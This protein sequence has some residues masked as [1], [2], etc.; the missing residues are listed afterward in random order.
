MRG[1]RPRGMLWTRSHSFLDWAGARV[2]CLPH[3]PS[4]NLLSLIVSGRKPENQVTEDISF[5][6]LQ[7]WHLS[8]FHKAV[9]P[10]NQ[11]LPS[12]QFPFGSMSP[13]INLHYAPILLTGT[14]RQNHKPR[15]ESSTWEVSI[16]QY[17]PVTGG[18]LKGAIYH[19]ENLSPAEAQLAG[20]L[21]EACRTSAWCQCS[22]QGR[23]KWKIS[24]TSTLSL[25]SPAVEAGFYLQKK[26]SV[27][28][29][30]SFKCHGPRI[31]D[32]LGDFFAFPTQFS[33][34]FP[35]NNFPS[36]VG[37]DRTFSLLW[38][39]WHLISCLL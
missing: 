24:R 3:S 1:W 31:E 10:V 7:Y 32:C 6:R 36:S 20:L 9:W 4:P 27:P 28:T 18:P 8:F 17:L 11:E 16:W 38:I 33:T 21:R 19:T 23:P 39:E 12:P 2:T 35:N 5:R 25:C 30:I 34:V 13:S 15:L 26:T 14:P 22:D 29:F 37:S